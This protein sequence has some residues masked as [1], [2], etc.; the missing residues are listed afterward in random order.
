M[1]KF[2]KM[3]V[4]LMREEASPLLDTIGFVS[5]PLSKSEYLKS[6]FSEERV[7][8][9]LQK[10]YKF[11]PLPA[12]KG[13]AAG[14]FSRPS[15]VE[16]NHEDLS[17]YMAENYEPSLFVIK[18]DEEQVMWMQ[19][20]RK[21]GSPK[22]IL[23]SFFDYLLKRTSLRDWQAFVRY[24]EGKENYWQAVEQYHHEITQ[25]IF[26]YVPPNAFEGKK[27]AQKYKTAMQ[28]EANS[29]V[30]EERFK[31]APGKMTPNSE[32][33]QANA[34]IAE[35]GAGEKELR[36]VGNRLLYSSRQGRVTETVVDDDMPDALNTSFVNRVIA[37]LFGS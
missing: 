21:V 22:R 23:E 13:Y 37:K 10:P 24:F 18:I 8:L 5:R 9:H 7:F 35:E 29:D 15:P 34:E 20:N 33:M 19:D 1:A 28:L 14:F 25:I 12:P 26:R 3:R 11:M 31:S 32:M 16:L 36:G 30:Y 17:P 4:S 6:A 2:E 27:L